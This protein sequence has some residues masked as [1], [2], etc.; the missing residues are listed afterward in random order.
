M[1]SIKDRNLCSITGD[2]F[3]R[4]G[5][6]CLVSVRDSRSRALNYDAGPFQPKVEIP[7]N[8]HDNLPPRVIQL[9]E[10]FYPRCAAL[11]P[12]LSAMITGMLFELSPAQL[13]MLLASEDSLEQRFNEAVAIAILGNRTTFCH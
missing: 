7:T 3:R 1:F 8:S 6:S 11:R 9:G 13:L 5:Q 10:R 12:I 4:H 2:Q